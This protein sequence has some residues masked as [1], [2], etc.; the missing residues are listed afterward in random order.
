MQE[1][2]FKIPMRSVMFHLDVAARDVH[3]RW[4]HA[5][6]LRR[7]VRPDMMR[8]HRLPPEGE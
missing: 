1:V 7:R 8:A 6:D 3:G 5:A 4:L 2:M